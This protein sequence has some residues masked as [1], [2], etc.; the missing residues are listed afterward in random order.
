[1]TMTRK[2]VCAILS[3][4]FVTVAQATMVD[5]GAPSPKSKCIRID[6]TIMR[7]DDDRVVASPRLTTT[8]G[9]TATLELLDGPGGD[10]TCLSFRARTVTRRLLRLDLSTDEGSR[11]KMLLLEEGSP[12]T[13]RLPGAERRHVRIAATILSSDAGS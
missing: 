10:G 13:I 6:T 8:D 1:M 4:S 12:V 9:G 7:S 5:K 3:L 2:I 11:A